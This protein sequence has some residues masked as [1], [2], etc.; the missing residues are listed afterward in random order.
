[1]EV[2]GHGRTQKTMFPMVLRGNWMSVVKFLAG[3][4]G[5]E[6]RLTESESAVLPLD[7]PPT[8]PGRREA[9]TFPR[10]AK[11][12]VGNVFNVAC[13]QGLL[14]AAIFCN[15]SLNMRGLLLTSIDARAHWPRLDIGK[16]S[17]AQYAC[18]LSW[19]GYFPVSAATAT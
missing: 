6:P 3:G 14:R 2:D 15:N 10:K 17:Q 16:F 19:R 4:L 18:R 9:G 12:A 1:M 8:Y 11:C 13:S 7:D 5:F